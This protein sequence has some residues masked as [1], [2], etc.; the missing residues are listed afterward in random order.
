MGPPYC[1]SISHILISNLKL[2]M[3]SSP[4]FRTTNSTTLYLSTM[5]RP[6]RT[7]RATQRDPT[8]LANK[9]LVSP[10]EAIDTSPIDPDLLDIAQSP[11]HT[12]LLGPYNSDQDD[13]LYNLPHDSP[14]DKDGDVPDNSDS[15]S[16]SSLPAVDTLTPGA[17]IHSFSGWTTEMEALMYSTLCIQV[18]LGKRADS[19]FKK[20]AWQAVCTAILS[21]YKVLVS[22]KQCKSKVDSQKLLWREYNS[23]K[24]QSGFGINESTGLIE[25]GEQAWRDVIVVSYNK[26]YYLLTTLVNY[27]NFIK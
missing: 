15:E 11:L 19:G 17:Q 5:N 22:T 21:T 26:S 24:D 13:S 18:E 2:L 1:G 3:L 4:R 27:T 10:F 7:K 25:A 16:D 6:T 12:E 23:L 14:L 20:D 8:S 9:A